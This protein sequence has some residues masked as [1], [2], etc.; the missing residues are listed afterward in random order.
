M[1]RLLPLLSR[2][3]N[4][5]KTLIVFVLIGVLSFAPGLLKRVEKGLEVSKGTLQSYVINRFADAVPVKASGF[6]DRYQ[7]DSYHTCHNTQSIQAILDR[8][9]G[10]A[11]RATMQGETLDMQGKINL[12]FEQGRWMTIYVYRDS[13]V[14][15]L[16]FRADDRQ[17]EYF[18]ANP[19]LN[20]SQIVQLMQ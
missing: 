18:V 8:L 9:S 7:S 15:R 20:I 11:L 17:D 16:S 10:V 5:H 4:R 6:Y 2:F 19:P 3:C 1:K 13:P 12:E 14:V